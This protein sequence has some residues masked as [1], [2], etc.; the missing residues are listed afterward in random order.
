MNELEIVP[1]HP[2][3]TAMQNNDCRKTPYAMEE[4]SGKMLKVEFDP[5]GVEQEVVLL[6]QKVDV[7]GYLDRLDARV[8][9]VGQTLA[10]QMRQICWPNFPLQKI[11]CKADTLSARSVAVNASRVDVKA[12][13]KRMREQAQSSK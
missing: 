8:G 2:T 11:S 3:V 9:E 6:A 5:V 1:I 10:G 4:L 12:P 7:E 13:L